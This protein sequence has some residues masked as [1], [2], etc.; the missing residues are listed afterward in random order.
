[1]T[2]FK[3]QDER[4]R[5]KLWIALGVL[6]V[7]MLGLSMFLTGPSPPRKITMATGLAGG[8]YDA[9][10]QQYQTSLGKMGLKVEL[11]NTNGSIDNLQRLAD[12]EVDVAFVQA[13]TYPLVSDPEHKLRGLVAIYLEPLWVFYRRSAPA[14]TLSD[15]KGGPL[16]P[17]AAAT[18]MT[19]LL[20]S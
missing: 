16:G 5:A 15:L 10:G 11:V 6:T 17:P 20:A 13:G 12:G 14:R 19:G 1:M 2:K 18:A 8:G 4:R 3:F 9:F 7:A